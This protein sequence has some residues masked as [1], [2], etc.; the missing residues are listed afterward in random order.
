MSLFDDDREE[1]PEKGYSEYLKLRGTLKH[2]ILNHFHVWLE[3]QL[4]EMKVEGEE[5]ELKTK[6]INDMK[7]EVKELSNDPKKFI[8]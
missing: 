3:Y 4:L 1:I 5:S 6:V 8:F 2:E 7:H